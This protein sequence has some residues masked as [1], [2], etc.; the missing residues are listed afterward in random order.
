MER[1]WGY[2]RIS[3]KKQNLE[4]QV[5]NILAEYPGAEIIEETY[6]GRNVLAR[7]K[8]EKLLK[9]IQT[10]DTVIFDS[11]SRMSRNAAE[12]FNLYKDL[13]GKGI[14][15][16]FL[17]ERH[18]NTETYRKELQKQIDLRVN[19]GE[20]AADELF[21]TIIDALNA[22]I[23]SL[24]EKQIRLAFEQSEKEV[25]DL[26]QRTKEGME[27]ARRKGRQIGGHK[28]GV[29][30]VIKKAAPVKELIRKYSRSFD[31]TLQDKNVMAII[32]AG[33]DLHVAP[34]TYYKYKR[35]MREG[36]VG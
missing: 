14:N 10:G 15:L 7:P 27:T 24:A 4:R 36:T 12:G 34:N 30:M 19:T 21:Q 1:V 16:V 25:E 23:L 32:N 6:T 3:T 35:E 8:F 13:Y 26:R 31:G 33:K 9:T 18:I 20:R 28:P 22:Y 2:A 11:V 29:K 5:R 17:K